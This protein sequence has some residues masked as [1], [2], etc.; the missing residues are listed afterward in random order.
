MGPYPIT[1]AP[2]LT[3]VLPPGV[4]EKN[5][6]GVVARE[7][8]RDAVLLGATGGCGAAYEEEVSL[9]VWE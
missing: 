2:E 9:R 5:G 7:G 1:G 8:G 3:G 6:A 4:E